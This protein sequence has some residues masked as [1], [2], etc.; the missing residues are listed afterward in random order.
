[1]WN[2]IKSWFGFADLNNDGKVDAADVQIAKTVVQA[3]VE[4]VKKVAAE[5]KRR[6]KDVKQELKDVKV[7]AKEL[8]SQAGDVVAAAKGKGRKAKK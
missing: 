2:K 6:V 3:R 8:S 7:A 4:T 1:M 5:T